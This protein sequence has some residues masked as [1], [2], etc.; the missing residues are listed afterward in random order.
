MNDNRP[1]ELPLPDMI[2]NLQSRVK[3]RLQE[4][5]EAIALLQTE[6]TEL[7]R[8]FPSE[9]DPSDAINR[10]T[11]GGTPMYLPRPVKTRRSRNPNPDGAPY[12]RPLSANQQTRA[13][14]LLAYLESKGPTRYSHI[15][16][17]LGTLFPTITP[18]SLGTDTSI[19]LRYL[20]SQGKIT[21]IEQGFYGAA[22]STP[23]STGTNPTGEIAASPAK[24]PKRKRR[25][26]KTSVSNANTLGEYPKKAGAVTKRVLDH[27][28]ATPSR[29]F[30][31]SEL[32]SFVGND[33]EGKRDP[34]HITNNL[35][36]TLVNNHYVT[37]ARRG[38]YRLSP[39][40]LTTPA[41]A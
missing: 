24:S 12:T 10:T 38:F 29:L 4:I 6:R 40:A 15:K 27:L 25:M 1:I 13:N 22:A 19:L 34:K 41:T 16:A 8:F 23:E 2:R 17:H 20:V 35:L 7:I 37:R 30:S 3:T 36:L 5:A 11:E 18:V 26:V 32:A 14:A 9:G 28:R 33:P 21:R 31:H 39:L